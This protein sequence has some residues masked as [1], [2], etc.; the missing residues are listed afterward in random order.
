MCNN[1]AL[2]FTRKGYIQVFKGTEF[3]SQHVS[4]FEAVESASEQGPG[5]YEIRFPILELDIAGGDVEPPPPPPPPPPPVI[6]PVEYPYTVFPMAAGGIFENDTN[7]TNQDARYRVMEVE[8]LD[9]TFEWFDGGKFVYTRGALT[10]T[11]SFKYEIKDYD[12]QGT[13][14]AATVTINVS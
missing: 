2:T 8:P 6:E 3:I 14:G 9:G 11:A 7:V 12:G 13:N 5:L 4:E 10:G 1:M